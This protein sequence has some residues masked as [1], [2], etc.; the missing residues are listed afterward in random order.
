MNDAQIEQTGARAHADLTP[1]QLFMFGLGIYVLLSLAAQ[2]FLSL[3]PG[4]DGI[5]DHVDDL[6]CV[7][8]FADFWVNLLT[9]KSKLAYLKWGWID[10]LSSI[11]MIDMARAGR[12]ARTIRIL[13]AFRGVRSARFL[14]DY[15]IHR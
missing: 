3:S 1:Y 7:A 6:V 14:A 12:L 4:T 15:L 5:L 11:P 8:F 10:L 13:R 2:T 9:A